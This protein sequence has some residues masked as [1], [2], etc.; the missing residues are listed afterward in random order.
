MIHIGNTGS[1]VE[2]TVQAPYP[3]GNLRFCLSW[4]AGS[5]WAASLLAHTL[6]RALGEKLA[7]IRSEAYQQGWKDAKAKRGNR[8]PDSFNGAWEGRT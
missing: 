5:E 3:I 2:A 7:N 8:G 6:R 1:N 4:N